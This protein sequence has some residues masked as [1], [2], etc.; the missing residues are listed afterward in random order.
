MV[1][2]SGQ[3]LVVS[4]QWGRFTVQ[5]GRSFGCL[6]LFFSPRWGLLFNFASTHRLRGG[7]HSFAASRLAFLGL[8]LGDGGYGS[9]G[10][11]GDYAALGKRA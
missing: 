1:G 10:A 8:I 7:L 9:F 2:G 11:Y 6:L 3:W 4:G 5:S